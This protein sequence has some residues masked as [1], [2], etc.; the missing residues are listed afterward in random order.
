MSKSAIVN[1]AFLPEKEK[2][3]IDISWQQFYYIC[4]GC[5]ESYINRIANFLFKPTVV[6]PVQCVRFFQPSLGYIFINYSLWEID[7]S[8]TERITSLLISETLNANCVHI[9]EKMVPAMYK[10]FNFCYV[11]TTEDKKTT[12]SY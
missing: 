12:T 4:L 5:S 1:Y 11:D 9:S 2:K 3:M 8:Q 6:L 10:E 7:L